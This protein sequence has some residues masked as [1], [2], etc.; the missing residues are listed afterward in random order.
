MP[1]EDKLVREGR[2][3]DLFSGIG[4]SSVLDSSKKLGDGESWRGFEM[5][6]RTFVY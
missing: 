3:Y 1:D 5:P 4:F 2:K 6:I